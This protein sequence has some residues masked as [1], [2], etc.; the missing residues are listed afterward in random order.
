MGIKL[1]KKT[2]LLYIT[3]VASG[4]LAI[5]GVSAYLTDSDYAGNIFR[6]GTNTIEG[7]EE[8]ETP[9]VGEITTKTPRAENTG[10]VDCYVRAFVSLSDHRAAGYIDYYTN[11]LEGILGTGWEEWEDNYYYYTP[12][13]SS[14]EVTTPLFTGIRLL[15]D[16]PSELTD[17]SIDV[18]FESAQAEGATDAWEAFE[19]IR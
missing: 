17:V 3:V 18:Y 4:I 8:F 15:E 10:S 5:N 13:L 7:R 12:I 19:Q 9:V 16:L 14:G 6:I 1:K 11:G 2:C